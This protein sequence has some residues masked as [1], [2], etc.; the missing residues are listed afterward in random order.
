[1][2]QL[3]NLCRRTRGPSQLGTRLRPQTGPTRLS[4]VNIPAKQSLECLVLNKLS[5]PASPGKVPKI[6]AGETL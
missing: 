3:L 5:A 4:I 1:M 6:S 2:Y